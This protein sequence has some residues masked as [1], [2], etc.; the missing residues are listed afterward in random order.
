MAYM[1]RRLGWPRRSLPI[2]SLQLLT[3]LLVR[4]F[5][6]LARW[7]E[8][9]RER[10]QLAALSDQALHDIGLSRADVERESRKPFWHP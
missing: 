3:S 10:Y 1:D 9:A 6:A 8:R 5:S 7:Q 2:A 4:L